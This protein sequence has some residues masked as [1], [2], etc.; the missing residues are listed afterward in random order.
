MTTTSTLG[1][2]LLAGAAGAFTLSLARSAARAQHGTAPAS[3]H[4]ELASAAA[5]LTIGTVG[6][7][8]RAAGWRPGAL[9]GAAAAGATSLG[10]GESAAA[11]AGAWAGPLAGPDDSPR[12][13]G[14]D[15]A[16]WLRRTAPHL[17]FGVSLQATL[18]ALE[19]AD[20]PVR[21]G[22]MP[23]R[24]AGAALVVRSALLG[25]AAGS[26]SSLG[27]AAPV[28]ARAVRSAH[29]SATPLAGI[30]MA[31]RAEVDLRALEAPRAPRTVSVV[32]SAGSVLGEIVADKLP[33]TPNRLE[34]GGLGA[35][36]VSGAAGATAMC[37]EHDA[38]SF[39]PALAGAGGAL[40]G[41]RAG[42]AWRASAGRWMPDWQAALV[43]DG[44]ALTLA[45]VATLSGRPRP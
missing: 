21:R 34:G 4:E 10:L 28:L 24:G 6:S 41:A 25:V 8:L 29:P 40:A 45:A 19:P 9:V 42:A 1:R 14:S 13:A 5:G 17:A 31:Q 7:A 44:I 15:G 30:D 18:S 27:V 38:T 32:A 23:A 39:W 35:R 33:A 3:A 11:R 2:G 36:L 20:A 12:Q 22:G 16:W 37:R 26:R 43:E